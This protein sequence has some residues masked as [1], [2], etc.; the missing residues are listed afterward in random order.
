MSPRSYVLVLIAAVVIIAAAIAMHQPG[1]GW[2]GH[3]A[4]AIHGHR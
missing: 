3:L 2:L 1:G 4:P